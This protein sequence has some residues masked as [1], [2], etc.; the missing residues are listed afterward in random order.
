MGRSSSPR[1]F[2]ARRFRRVVR[3]VEKHV[4]DIPLETAWNDHRTRVTEAIERGRATRPVTIL[5]EFVALSEQEEAVL[6]ERFP[7]LAG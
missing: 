4:G 5:D 7:H 6:A 2:P 1:H 3:S